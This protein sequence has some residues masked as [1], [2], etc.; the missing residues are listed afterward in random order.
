MTLHPIPLNFLIY[1]ENFYFLFYQCGLP[2][3]GQS[4]LD[5]SRDQIYTY[6]TP[7]DGMLE[8]QGVQAPGHYHLLSCLVASRLQQGRVLKGGGGGGL[9]GG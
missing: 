8:F 3:S 4:L 9:I 2:P 7:D 6:L 1:E 5:P